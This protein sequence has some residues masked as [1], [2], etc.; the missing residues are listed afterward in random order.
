MTP[1]LVTVI[2]AA[3]VLSLFLALVATGARS[4]HIGRRPTVLG[5]LMVNVI[6]MVMF[7]T[8]AFGAALIA[9]SRA[10]VR[11]VARA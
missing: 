7:I 1:A 9:V 10:R 4:D 8:A 2:F 6:A 3:Y 5:A 11:P